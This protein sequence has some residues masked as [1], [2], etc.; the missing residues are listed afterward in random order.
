MPEEVVPERLYKYEGFNTQSLE[1]LKAQSLFF[2][3]PKGF[4]DPYDCGI[5]PHIKEMAD[6]DVQLVVDSFL[7]D[8][9]ANTQIRAQI[10]RMSI[11]ELRNV[12]C[13]S[14]KKTLA[15]RVGGF[16]TSRG[17][18][19]FSETND[20]LLMWSHYGGRYRGFCLEFDTACLSEFKF[21][22]V[23]YSQIL[24]TVDLVPI[25]L[26]QGDDNEVMQMYATKAEAWKYEREWRAFHKVAG[27]LYC[28]PVTALTGVYFGPEIALESLE[29]ICLILRGQ[30]RKVR[31]WRGHRSSTQFRVEFEEVIYH[32][33]LEAEKGQRS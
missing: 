27:T 4:N 7:D 17:V 8:P 32:S 16:A 22:K 18:T 28:Y 25:M 14:G 30:N 1:N 13:A 24:P 12:F 31:F 9:G 3:S 5:I 2:G 33:H 26:Q 21:K 19:C 23:R 15:E 6:S 20:D 11:N 29:I 10:E